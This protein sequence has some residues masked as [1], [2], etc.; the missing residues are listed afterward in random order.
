[1]PLP[2]Y[3]AGAVALPNLGQ[4]CVLGGK[5]DI[6]LDTSNMDTVVCLSA[7]DQTWEESTVMTPLPKK[8]AWITAVT[9]TI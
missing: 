4:V 5:Y 8:M 9:Y 7:L 2:R 3:A 6:L 1:M